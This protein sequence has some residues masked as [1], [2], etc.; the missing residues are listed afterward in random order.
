MNYRKEGHGFTLV[1]LL[2]VLAII[3]LLAAI[4]LPILAGA[5]RRA[6]GAACK[7]RLRRTPLHQG[8]GRGTPA[9][10]QPATESLARLAK[11]RPHSLTEA[12][13]RNSMARAGDRHNA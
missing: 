11:R 3:G 12:D 2:V 9:N 10:L 7:S 4:L 1:E 13:R 6:E 8:N 5:K